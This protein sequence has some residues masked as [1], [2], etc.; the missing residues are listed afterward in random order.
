MVEV[1]VPL[2][3]MLV[4]TEFEYCLQRLVCGLAIIT[5]AITR[6]R[7]SFIGVVEAIRLFQKFQ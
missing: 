3:T 4:P 5:D 2:V 1:F 7:S 6:S